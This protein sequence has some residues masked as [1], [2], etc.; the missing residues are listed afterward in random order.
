[1]DDTERVLVDVWD[2]PTR[3]LHWLNAGIVIAL[4]VLILGAEWMEELGVAR[5]CAAR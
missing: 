3:I 2:W 1:M 5:N 4:I